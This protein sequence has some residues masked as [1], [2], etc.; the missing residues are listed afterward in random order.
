MT[1]AVLCCKTAQGWPPSAPASQCQ[2][3]GSALGQSHSKPEQQGG[4]SSLF[5]SL[6]QAGRPRGRRVG[7]VAS[8]TPDEETEAKESLHT[9]GA[10]H[11]TPSL[12][13]EPTPLCSHTLSPLAIESHLGFPHTGKRNGKSQTQRVPENQRQMIQ[14]IICVHKLFDFFFFLLLISPSSC[15]YS[16]IFFFYLLTF[17][18]FLLWICRKSLII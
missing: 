9:E 15:I 17:S 7:D 1:E 2:A 14:R 8:I 10:H 11:P 3:A 4:L 12:N 6:G 16:D 18:H 13:T 5:S